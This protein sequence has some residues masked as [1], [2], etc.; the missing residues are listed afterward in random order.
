MK[1]DVIFY[2]WKEEDQLFTVCMVGVSSLY[3]QSLP[4]LDPV[5]SALAA[6][7][8]FAVSTAGQR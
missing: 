8:R 3:K 5:W 7:Y 1:S 2:V 6:S 4:V